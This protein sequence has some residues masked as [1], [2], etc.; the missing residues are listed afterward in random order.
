M[1]VKKDKIELTLQEVIII[2]LLCKELSNSQIAEKLGLS[3]H[4]VKYHNKKIYR[5]VKCESLLG[6]YKYALK[7]GI[8]NLK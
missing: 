7:K 3:I 1:P 4:G 8:V 5:K 2:K 6:L